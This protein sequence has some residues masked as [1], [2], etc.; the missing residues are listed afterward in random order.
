MG[1]DIYHVHLEVLLRQQ[2]VLVLGVDV[3]ESR[4]QLTQCGHLDGG[5]VDE[6]TALAGGREL[7][8]KYALLAVEVELMA[9]EEVVH[10]IAREVELGL[11]DTACGPGLHHAGLGTLA[12]QQPD[13]S[14]EDALAGTRLAGND[15]EAP[16]EAY[17]ERGDEGEVLYSERL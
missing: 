5:V 13:G 10:A 15:G 1:N 14:E 11:D 7:A 12:E 2:Q 9:L 6:G 8:A 4:A 3:Y 16:L 17:V